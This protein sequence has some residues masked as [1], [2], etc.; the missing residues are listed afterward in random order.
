MTG[1]GIFEDLRAISER[2]VPV[3]L[4]SL[5]QAGLAALVLWGVLKV[6]PASK[7]GR[8]YGA[9]LCA[10]L[11]VVMCAAGTW[12]WMGR[13]GF[14][15]GKPVVIEVTRFAH[16]REVVLGPEVKDVMIAASQPAGP[17]IRQS[18]PDE[19]I[20][21]RMGWMQWV[22]LAWMLGAG[23]GMLR[24]MR[25]LAG[26]GLLIKH[27][28][29]VDDP[30]WL[31]ALS[32]TCAALGLTRRVRLALSDGVRVPTVAGLLTPVVLIP[33]FAAP[34][35]TG[36]ALKMIL[37]HELTHVRRHDLWIGLFES[38]VEA[39]L[40]FNPAVRWI[41]RQMKV[42]R[43]CCCD[44]VSARVCDSGPAGYA[45]LLAAWA[46][47]EPI[48]KLGHNDLV[49]GFD[50]GVKTRS[51]TVERMVRVLFPSR[52]VTRKAPV[53]ALVAGVG[54]F[55][56][57]SAATGVMAQTVV[58][59]VVRALTPAER[60]E[61]MAKALPIPVTDQER[62]F[63]SS[64]P[65]LELTVTPAPGKQFTSGA[66]VQ[67]FSQGRYVGEE[68]GGE[69]H[70]SIGLMDRV[71]DLDRF[72]GITGWVC[73][74]EKSTG[75]TVKGPIERNKLP[76]VMENGEPYVKVS[77]EVGG[78]RRRTVRVVDE[79]DA[80]V[81]RAKV[82]VMAA[83]RPSR[84]VQM[85]GVPHV[86]ETDESGRVSFDVNSSV[87]VVVR[88]YAKG[89]MPAT[90]WI[91]PGGPDEQKLV[92]KPA[93]VTRGRLVWGTTGKPM[94]NE[95]V[96]ISSYSLETPTSEYQ[97]LSI[98]GWIV[99]QWMH[100]KTDN[101]GRFSF[102][103]LEEGWRYSLSFGSSI[104]EIPDVA[105]GVDLG[106]VA[107]GR[108]RIKGRVIDS[109]N[110]LADGKGKVWVR[111]LAGGIGGGPERVKKSETG[112][113]MLDSGEM[114]PGRVDVMYI[115]QGR[116]V[117]MFDRELKG[118]E[119]LEGLEFDIRKALGPQPKTSP[120][121]IKVQVPEGNPAPV[122][123][124]RLSPDLDGK[125]EVWFT[126]QDKGRK[127]VMLDQGQR[128]DTY[129]GTQFLGFRV[130]RGASFKVPEDGSAKE[131]TVELMQAVAVVGKVMTPEGKPWPVFRLRLGIVDDKGKMS[132]LVGSDLESRPQK[133]EGR[134]A[135]DILELGKTYI[136]KVVVQR[137]DGVEEVHDLGPYLMTKERSVREGD[138]VVGRGRVG[139]W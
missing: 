9:S 30:A 44:E 119:V 126:A 109:D 89:R 1:E 10:L 78:G 39:L 95:D 32:Q 34:G 104:G 8:R 83:L 21:P 17:V 43:E 94:P 134:F 47:Q 130:L 77:M 61:V 5:W 15:P 63:S 53:W 86:W 125:G 7:P 79:A 114:Q 48:Q 101:E 92:T 57:A 11:A 12:A 82:A 97:G 112:E 75:V 22:A 124:V 66:L 127:T 105:A 133:G 67:F 73:I 80:P 137:S 24:S 51:L 120:V 45:R 138:V 37:A 103:I 23:F 70:N 31:E 71:Y 46:T 115:G 4:H 19:V 50:G 52:S 2:V 69:A 60:V 65:K 68:H 54:A 116:H 59:T 98:R 129:T 139:T 107:V 118:G 135:V 20:Y 16:E 108:V 58:K 49:M 117:K 128:Y 72:H 29:D 122:G 100:T 111:S 131:V 35:L 99:R 3:L 74:I 85:L 91:A 56:M 36:E 84:Q 27:S 13:Q 62:Y 132:E 106:D 64:P 42:E 33:G 55:L 38:V 26:A 41:A 40:F 93:Q 113:L 90:A 88:V 6:T 123:V 28:R 81:A 96:R 110:L 121:T 102:D 136:V 87:P 14:I 25:D 18:Q 76:V